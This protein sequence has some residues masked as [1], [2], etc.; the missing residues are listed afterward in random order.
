MKILVPLPDRD[1]DTTEVAIPWHVFVRAGHQ[2]VFATEHGAAAAC[3]PKL[4][5]GVI[6]G[7]LGAEAEACQRYA[8]MIAS[9]GFQAPI[10]WD[11]IVP[12][13]YAALLL[14]GGHAQGVRQYLD[15]A[16]LQQ[17]VGGFAALDRPI[18]AICHGVLL[19][20]RACDPASGA[21]LLAGRRAT[22]LPKYLE[23]SAF[24]L[25]AWRLGRYYRT[26]PDYTEDEV[27]A[28][29]GAHGQFERGPIQFIA[30]GSDQDDSAAFVVEDGNLLTARWPGDV[31]L[32]AKSLLGKL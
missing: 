11:Q 32:L 5:D 30:K 25:T 4:L 19:L 28:A 16:L 21:S 14:P 10:R 22:C 18:A 8:E 20:A 23:R 31:W 29:I 27:R 24:Y 9:P 13:D 15:S 12:A 2:V 3:D 6:F 1:F 17:Q 7:Q 26:Y